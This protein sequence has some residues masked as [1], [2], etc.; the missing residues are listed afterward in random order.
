MDQ[1]SLIEADPVIEAYKQHVDRSLIRANL[2]RTVE[3][4][5]E[6]LAAMHAVARDLRQGMEAA[7]MPS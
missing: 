3:E 4:R 7:R 1:A 6:R 5:F 2:D